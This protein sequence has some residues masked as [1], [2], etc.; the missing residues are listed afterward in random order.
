MKLTVHTR[1]KNIWR[2]GN[3][4][5][6]LCASLPPLSPSKITTDK[7]EGET[8]GVESRLLSSVS[9]SFRSQSQAL[10]RVLWGW[11]AQ[12][13]TD[14][15]ECRIAEGGERNRSGSE[16]EAIGVERAGCKWRMDGWQHPGRHGRVVSPASSHVTS[17]ILKTIDSFLLVVG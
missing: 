9:L 5:S 15:A 1:A 2:E 17:F 10:T 16:I 11:R 3:P 13:E 4:S 8:R 12:S 7:K 6:L 14:G